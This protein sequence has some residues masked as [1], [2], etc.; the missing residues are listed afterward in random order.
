MRRVRFGETERQPYCPLFKHPR[1]PRSK[2]F[3]QLALSQIASWRPCC[4]S[5][6]VLSIAKRPSLPVFPSH[7]DRFFRRFFKGC[8]QE[9]AKNCENPF[10]SNQ[11]RVE[12]VALDE[13]PFVF[14]RSASTKRVKTAAAGS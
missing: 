7:C 12:L 8:G 13:R 6:R 3:K 14:P 10:I 4:L 1:L 11:Y 5:R 9:T 2:S